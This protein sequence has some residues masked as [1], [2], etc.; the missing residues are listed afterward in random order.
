MLR[1]DDLHPPGVTSKPEHR[2]SQEQ[3]PSIGT[4]AKYSKSLVSVA[5]RQHILAYGQGGSAIAG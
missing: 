1:R 5:F 2:R 4:A 3:T